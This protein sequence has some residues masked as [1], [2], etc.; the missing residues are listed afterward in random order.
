MLD[1]T[2]HDARNAV[3]LSEISSRQD[4]SLSYLE[5]LFAKLRKQG[6][7][8]SSR[9]PGGGYRLA[10]DANS[11]YISDIIL[12]V[13]E[14]LDVRKCKGRA[15]CGKNSSYCITHNLWNNLTDQIQGFLKNISL[16]DLVNDFDDVVLG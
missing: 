6:L 15:N 12:A 7:V 9:G 14:S 5:Q 10:A 1:L 4:I 11:T 13:D 16:A 2:L 3:S 8:V